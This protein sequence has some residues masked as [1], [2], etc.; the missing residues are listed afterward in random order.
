M[1]VILPEKIEKIDINSAEY[2]E[3]LKRISN[4][5]QELYFAGDISLL[6]GPCAAVVG[7]R[8]YTVYGKNVA[9]MIG[10]RFAECGISVVSG[11]AL[12]IDGFA[13]RGTVD[14]GG[15]IIGVLGSGINRMSPQRNISLMIEGLE[16]GGL[17]ISEY[18]P[19]E[20]AK[21][22]TFPARNRIISALGEILILVEAS[23][24]SGALITAKFAN[25]QGRTIYAVPGNI[26]SQFSAGC[27]LL[28][29]DGAVPLVVIDDAIR[30]MGII[31]SAERREEKERAGDDEEA[32][33]RV[34]RKYGSVSADSIARELGTR[35][36]AV[37]ALITVMEI[38]GLVETAGGKIHL[39]N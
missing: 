16:K 23:H 15:K 35:P 14:A 32:V 4:P 5:P 6:R 29:R 3:R 37:G 17:V 34:V 21:P 1:A 9:M 39:A 24:N 7:S 38:K 30:D 26:N 2:P 36:A 33:L 27:N 28:I 18:E 12:G 8:K 31:P 10:S 19:Y 25:E 22:Y 11:L 13:H 20:E